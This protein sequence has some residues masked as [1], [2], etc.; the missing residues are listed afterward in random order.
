MDNLFL[1][2]ILGINWIIRVH[3]VQLGE[4]L[5][6]SLITPV[7]KLFQYSPDAEILGH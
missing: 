2:E 7:T 5:S 4:I 6:N 1:G 3:V